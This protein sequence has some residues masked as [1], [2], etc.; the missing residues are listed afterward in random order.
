MTNFNPMAFNANLFVKTSNEIDNNSEIN[1]FYHPRCADSVSEDGVYRA[2]IKVLYN[3]FEFTKSLVEQQVYSL[4]DE[5]GWFPVVSSLSNGDKSCP[6][7]TLWKSLRYSDDETKQMLAKPENAG[8]K[9]Y[10]NKSNQTYVT[11]QVIEDKNHPELEHQ[12]L[13]WKCPKQILS[14][15]ENKQNPS[16]DS[17]KAGI[18]IMD[19]LYGRAIDLEIVPGPDDKAHP[20]R[21]TRETSYLTSEITDD[22]YTC[23]NKDGSSIL[24]DE[25]TAMVE[26]YV[27]KMTKILK[28]RDVEKRN[29]SMDEL[30]SSE[31]SQK[32]GN[33]YVNK[34]IPAVKEQCPNVYEQMSFKGWNDELTAR[35]N[36]WIEKVKNG[37][38][39]KSPSGGSIE[40]L[41]NSVVIEK[42]ETTTTEDE[43]L[44]F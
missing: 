3:P 30:C 41:T 13:I 43:S 28:I 6:I 2:L 24:S 5:N 23:T 42:V 4:N 9:G 39:P 22:V 15:I 32:L 36:K 8:G 21:R 10:F 37:V 44:P 38:D 34:L 29:T 40:T 18:P 27:E 19:L 35:V 1:I 33:L 20:E 16:V 11:I 12:Y 7:F 14:M 25:E 17:G 31:L 26:E